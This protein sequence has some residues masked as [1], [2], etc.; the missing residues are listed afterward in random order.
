MHPLHYSNVVS[1]LYLSIRFSVKGIVFY[2]SIL[3]DYSLA[4]ITINFLLYF[5]FSLMQIGNSI[6]NEMTQSLRDDYGVK[7][8][9]RHSRRVTRAWDRLQEKVSTEYEF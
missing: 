4:C 8:N 7:L 1:N 9:T 6:R 3:Y 5:V 2:Q